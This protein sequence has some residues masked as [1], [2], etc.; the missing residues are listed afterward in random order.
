[1]LRIL[2][3]LVI[4][5]VANTTAHAGIYFTHYNVH[6]D[7]EAVP[8][9]KRQNFRQRVNGTHAGGA[10][11]GDDAA[12]VSACG[13]GF[14]GGHI[15]SALCVGWDVLKGELQ[16]AADALVGV[17]G[18]GGGEDFFARVQLSGH[19]ERFEVGHGAAAGEVAQEGGPAEHG[20]E[21]GDGLFLH[22]GTGF[23]AVERMVVGVDPEGQGVGG[24]GDG[25]GW[26]QHLARVERVK[27]RVIIVKEA[28]GLVQDFGHLGVAWN[29]GGEGGQ[30]G[31]AVVQ[32]AQ[33]VGEELQGPGFEHVVGL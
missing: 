12:D 1:M 4:A 23:A 25:V 18:L 27:V 22:G 21:L 2:F 24:A 29:G 26:L 33:G 13:E 3:A 16:N 11:G 15:H 5:M 10:E 7:A 9:T 20:G 32:V 17:V 6:M 28:G 8:L 30:V 14:E 19:P 31:E